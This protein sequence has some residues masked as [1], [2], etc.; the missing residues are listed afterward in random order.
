MLSRAESQQCR[1]L[2]TVFQRAGELGY[3]GRRF[4]DGFMFSKAAAN[5]F[6]SYDRL[7]WLGKGYL[8]DEIAEELAQT[9]STASSRTN[10]EAL[11]WTW[12][13]YR[14]WNYRTGESAPEISKTANAADMFGVWEGY[15][16][17][18]PDEAIDRLKESSRNFEV[19]KHH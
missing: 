9:P 11:Y 18:S 1:I 19:N 6:S 13:V 5:L 16:T 15:H 2:G 10:P 3:D 17:L 14:W 7:Q 4:V 12:Y 8:L